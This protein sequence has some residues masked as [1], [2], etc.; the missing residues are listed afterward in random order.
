MNPSS[1]MHP[2]EETIERY[3]RGKLSNA[4]LDAFEEHL[5]TCVPCQSCAEELDTFVRTIREAAQ[6]LEHQPPLRRDWF[7]SM[8]ISGLRLAWTAAFVA[9]A[10]LVIVIPARS[11]G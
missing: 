11:P 4:E 9:V 2:P 3:V 5:L 7:W 6:E 8:P 1:P 10:A